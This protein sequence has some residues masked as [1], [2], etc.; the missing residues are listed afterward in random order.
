MTKR[1]EMTRITGPEPMTLIFLEGTFEALPL[2]VRMQGPWAG[3]SYGNMA[4]LKPAWRAAISKSGY[5]IIAEAVN[6][7]D[8]A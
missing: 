1:Y 4:T 5:A 6:L 2:E 3:C 7:L 8:A